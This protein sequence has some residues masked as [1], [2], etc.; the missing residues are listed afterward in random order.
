M[1]INRFNANLYRNIC[2]IIKIIILYHNFLSDHIL[3]HVEY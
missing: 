2:K 1:Q 3:E